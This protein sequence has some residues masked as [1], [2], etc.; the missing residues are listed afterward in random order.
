MAKERREI[1]MLIS[2]E[3]GPVV[4]TG[5][6]RPGC[7]VNRMSRGA[8]SEDVDNHSL[9]EAV[10]IGADESVLGLPAHAD[11]RRLG[12]YPLPVDTKVNRVSVSADG[13]LGRSGS[14]EIRLTEQ[15]ASEKKRSIYGRELDLLEAIAGLHVEEVIKKSFVSRD[16]RRLWTLRC[17]VHEAQRR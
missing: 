5:P 12:P 16:C 4:G 6:F 8:E 11:E 7:R 13:G 2:V 10:P 3:I 14:G 17:V 15:N 9:V 1:H